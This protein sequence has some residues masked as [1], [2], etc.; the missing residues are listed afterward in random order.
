M[1]KGE[2]PCAALLPE[3][4][5]IWQS[6]GLHPPHVAASRGLEAL[7]CAVPPRPGWLQVSGTS[8]APHGLGPRNPTHTFLGSEGLSWGFLHKSFFPAASPLSCTFPLDLVVFSSSTG[9]LSCLWVSHPG[10]LHFS[11]CGEGQ[12][13]QMKELM[14]WKALGSVLHIALGHTSWAP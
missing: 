2:P 9:M 1:I 14:L 12:D 6:L 13:M 7:S 11:K 10:S 5:A 4:A 8:P 3:A